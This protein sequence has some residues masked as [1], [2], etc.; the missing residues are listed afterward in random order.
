M[1]ILHVSAELF[2]LLKTGGLADV[3][4]ALPLAL[5]A[6]GQDVRVLLP[7]FPAV[8][9][10]VAR[11]GHRWPNSRRRGASAS[12]CAS[13]ASPSTGRRT[14]GLRDRRADALRPAR[15]PLRGSRAANPTATT[16]AASRC[17]AGRPRSSRRASIRPGSPR[18]CTRT[19]GTPRWRR[20]ISH[21]RHPTAGRASAPCSPCTTSPTR[22]CSR[23][24]I[25]LIWAC[26]RRPFQRQRPRVLRPAVVHEGR[27]VL[28]RPH[29][30]REP[31]LCARDPDARA[32]LRPRRPA[33][34]PLRACSAASSTP[35]T[36]RSGIRPPTC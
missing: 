28:R 25:S 7:G 18:S 13:A 10:G 19:T 35:S 30:D 34:H 24:G 31:D 11:C 15:Q 16:I 4:G 26:R 8:V 20:P 5:M 36:T 23:P 12:S 22:A 27:P 1:R 9:A 17:S 2:P 3:A 21:S 33:A 6:A 32:G 14:S 29:H